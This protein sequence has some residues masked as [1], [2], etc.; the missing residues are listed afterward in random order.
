MPWVPLS[1]KAS[2]ALGRRWRRARRAST[3]TRRLPPPHPNLARSRTHPLPLSLSLALKGTLPR[4]WGRQRS[5]A[6]INLA[7]NRLS[8]TL[9]C[10]CVR[11]RAAAR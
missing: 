9:V 4:D 7:N 10:V 3:L 1:R 8:G 2:T 11:K 5:I 6:A